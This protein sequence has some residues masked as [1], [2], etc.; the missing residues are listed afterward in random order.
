M[1]AVFTAISAVSSLAAGA[2][3]R[4]QYQQ[5]AKQAELRGRSEALAYK[6]QGVDASQP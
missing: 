1:G 2:E 4:R 3:Q 5:Q 6:Q